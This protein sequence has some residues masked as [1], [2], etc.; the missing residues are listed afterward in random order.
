M[1]IIENI[2]CVLSEKKYP[3]KTFFCYTLEGTE[4]A[5]GIEKEAAGEE[6]RGGQKEESS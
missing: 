4:T 3:L 6:G 2:F 5:R 1:H